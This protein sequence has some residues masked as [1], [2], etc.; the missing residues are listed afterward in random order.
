MAK[1]KYNVGD[2]TKIFLKGESP[3]GTVV[4]FTEKKD[5]D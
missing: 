2:Q 5:P 4:E 1:T 3:W